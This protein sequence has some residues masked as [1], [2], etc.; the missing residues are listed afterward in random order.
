[1]RDAKCICVFIDSVA[2]F[3]LA[4][5]PEFISEGTVRPEQRTVCYAL[6]FSNQVFGAIKY[7]D[8]SRKPNKPYEVYLISKIRVQKYI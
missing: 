7:S 4:Q 1:M 2:L 8:R 5:V 6:R 3:L